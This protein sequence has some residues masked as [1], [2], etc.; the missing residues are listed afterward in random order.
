MRENTQAVF[1]NFPHN[2][3]GAVAS[4]AEL[5]EIVQVCRKAGA[6]LFSDEMYR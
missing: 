3:S 4:P 6:F 1:I 5:D 2:P